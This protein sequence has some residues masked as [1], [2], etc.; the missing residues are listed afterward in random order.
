MTDLDLDL[1]AEIDL[2]Q[3]HLTVSSGSE[4][5]WTV[6]YQG[7]PLCVPKITRSEAERVAEMFKLKPTAIWNADLGKFETLQAEW[8][9]HAAKL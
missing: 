2:H 3:C 6:F 8:K 7:L 4:G 9:R 5:G 1:Q